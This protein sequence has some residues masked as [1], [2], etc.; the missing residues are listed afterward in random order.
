MVL[1]KKSTL[2]TTYSAR[3]VAGTLKIKESHTTKSKTKKNNLTEILVYKRLKGHFDIFFELAK[4]NS[5]CP[6]ET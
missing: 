5:V 3:E 4:L 2:Y 6:E 1:K